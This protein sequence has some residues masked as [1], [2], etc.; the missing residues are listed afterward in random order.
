MAKIKNIMDNDDYSTY[1]SFEDDIDIVITTDKNIDDAISQTLERQLDGIV[2]SPISE[3]LREAEE[4]ISFRDNGDKSLDIK[5]DLNMD[6]SN[7]AQSANFLD[8][9]ADEL[10]DNEQDMFDDPLS[11]DEIID[12]VND[13]K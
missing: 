13:I 10:R 7:V 11:D 5:L 2:S 9:D 6:C 12:I 4:K 1:D 3:A 8:M